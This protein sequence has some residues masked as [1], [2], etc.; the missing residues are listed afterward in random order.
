MACTMFPAFSE[1]EE[2]LIEKRREE[3]RREEERG[4]ERRGEKRSEDK[5]REEKRRIP[6]LSVASSRS[7]PSA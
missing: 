3:K 7:S 6:I 2:V 5:K 1:R 4:E